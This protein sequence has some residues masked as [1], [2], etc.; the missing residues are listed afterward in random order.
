MP[1]H[2]LCVKGCAMHRCRWQACTDAGGKHAHLHACSNFVYQTDTSRTASGKAVVK[3]Y[4]VP[5]RKVGTG[6]TPTCCPHS[7]MR[8]IAMLLAIDRISQECGFTDLLPR[9]WVDRVSVRTLCTCME[10]L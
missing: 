9:L 5:V 4:C 6:K 7:T 3:V 1:T 8:T 10:S 2:V